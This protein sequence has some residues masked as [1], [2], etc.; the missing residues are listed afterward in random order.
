MTFNTGHGTNLYL[1]LLKKNR[2]TAIN[3]KTKCSSK[4]LGNQSIELPILKAAQTLVKI[5]NCI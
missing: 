3:A 4:S 1:P 5:L 2:F